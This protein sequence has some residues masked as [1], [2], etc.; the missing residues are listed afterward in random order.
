MEKAAE[1]AAAFYEKTPV[2]PPPRPP[3][4]VFNASA[5]RYTPA[6]LS[7]GVPPPAAPGDVEALL[8]A[9][10]LEPAEFG[11]IVHAYLEAPVYRGENRIPPRFLARL[12]EKAAAAVDAAARDMAEKF[13]ASDLGRRSMTD[14]NRETEYP[15][16]TMVQNG[17][18]KAPLYG[19]IDLLFESEGAVWVVDFKT[20]KTEEPERHL[21]QLAVYSRAAADIFGKPVRAWV[22]FLRTGHA[23]ELTAGLE[24]VDLE[25]IIA[26]SG[27]LPPD[28]RP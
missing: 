9:A 25:K 8:E 26:L 16:I 13:L 27:G 6:S 14:P 11:T 18:K 19:K 10:N 24:N 5:L 23:R 4:P 20:D 2:V 21:A 12:S 1:A 17:E 28:S 22:F 3:A 15:I 7:A